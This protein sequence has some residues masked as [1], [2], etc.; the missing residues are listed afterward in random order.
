VVHES[1]GHGVVMSVDDP[2]VTV[3]FEDAG[4]RA[5]DTRLVKDG[6]MLRPT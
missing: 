3:L 5:L 4:Y 6:G 2:G 1:F